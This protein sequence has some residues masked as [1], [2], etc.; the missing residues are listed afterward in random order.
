MKQEFL[1]SG[2]MKITRETIDVPGGVVTLPNVI[3]IEFSDNWCAAF[4]SEPNK[5]KYE[6]V[7]VPGG[8]LRIPNQKLSNPSRAYERCLVVD[9]IKTQLATQ[10]IRQIRRRGVADAE[11][12]AGRM[13]FSGVV[14]DEFL[15][16]IQGISPQ[17]CAACRKLY[18]HR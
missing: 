13:V 2:L 3:Q 9:L 16:S 11:Q 12:S 17:T 14:S 6:K 10:K 8:I 4:V 15:T 1:I 7:N 5:T 18:N